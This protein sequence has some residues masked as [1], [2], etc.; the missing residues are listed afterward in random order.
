MAEAET[1][2]SDESAR[3]QKWL[4]EIRVAKN[5][6][7]GWI[8][9]GKRIVRRYKDE[10][11]DAFMGARFN[12][13]WSNT[14]TIFPAVYSRTP[15][16]EVSRRN[17]DA[18]PIA[19]TAAQILERSLQY[20][21]DQYPDF[22]EA[23]KQA[24][25]DRLLPGRGVTWLRFETED[26]E[27][28]TEGQQQSQV[29]EVGAE[30]Q[31]L[32]GLLGGQPMMPPAQPQVRQHACVDYVF[33]QDFRH[34]AAR[35][36]A[37]VPW[38]ARRVYMSREE[39][40]KRFGEGFKDVPLTFEPIG[41]DDE[42]RKDGCDDSMRKAQ[43]WEIWDKTDKKAI[44]V[45]EGYA[46]VLDER[47]DPYELEGFFPCPK[48]LYATLTTE[49]LIPTPDF[50]LYQDQANELDLL[51][52]RIDGL[53]KALRLVGAY[54]SSNSELARM[55]ESPDNTMVPVSNWANLSEKG[56]VAGVVSWLPLREVVAALQ[57][58]YLARDQVKQ[59]I[60][61]ITGISDIIRG[62]TKAS[63][64]YGAQEIK[65]QFGS[66][67]LQVRQRDVAQHASEILRIKAQLMMDLYDPQTLIA[68]S[69]IM[70]T[71]DGQYAEQALAL[72]RQEPMREYR[73]TVATDS[74]VAMDE[75]QEKAERTEF[76]AAVGA[77]LDRAVQAA[78][79]L[80]ELAPLLGELLM[81]GVRAYPAAK[82]VEGA[83]DEFM[84]ALQ[85]RPPQDPN[86]QANAEAQ[87]EQQ[88][89]Q[90][91][92]QIEQMRMQMQ[93]QQKQMELQAD[94]QANQIRAQADI[95]IQQAKLSMQA[96]LERNRAQMQAGIDRYRAEVDAQSK[97]QIA[98]LQMQFQRW[99]AELDAAVKVETA[100]I[101]AK[102]KVDNEATQTATREIASEVTQ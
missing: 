31:I 39:G 88:K 94:A 58:A 98:E 33:W 6:E 80:P 56:G 19:R 53:I 69:G 13:L 79:V 11:Q 83:F 82:P 84:Q 54:D 34:G 75:E 35:N 99:K 74:L 78:Q 102:A 89:L 22:D 93:G 2:T 44:W 45:A 25:L 32:G 48:P 96:E 24:I 12:I 37:A 95:Q 7:D 61:E 8:Q 63:E 91:Q 85:N 14:E 64:T 57:A 46:K 36:W 41:L 5:V 40:A 50:A 52:T 76:L 16:A 67:R 81:F 4:T 70:D 23:L 66:L 60:Y 97:A 1:Q 87:A 86:A 68:M 90:Q 59:S 49:S 65:R 27:E 17:K 77:Y 38:V 21:I 43:V 15:K 72:M 51:T 28:V 42:A 10:R 3:A 100:N 73:I 62:A 55:L 29:G 9:R 101:A 18:D 30:A 71:Q 20:E 92:A 47:D 26:G